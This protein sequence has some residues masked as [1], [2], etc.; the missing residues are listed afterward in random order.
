MFQCSGKLDPSLASSCHEPPRSRLLGGLLRGR[1][2][3]VSQ[4]SWRL[5]IGA[6]LRRLDCCRRRNDVRVSANEERQM[7]D[8]RGV[9]WLTNRSFVRLDLKPEGKNGTEDHQSIHVQAA[10]AA[11]QVAHLT[12]MP[13]WWAN[14]RAD[15]ERSWWT[16]PGS[17]R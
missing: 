12:R 6:S 10:T 3:A 15:R 1:R 9:C 17:N 5:W 11:W 7:R 2:L 4:Q 13:L 16:R 8:A 14:L